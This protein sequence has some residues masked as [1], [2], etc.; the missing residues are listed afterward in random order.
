MFNIY[1]IN[2]SLDGSAII[3]ASAA[4][5]AAILSAIISTGF[6]H[7][8]QKKRDKRNNDLKV[9][10]IE[11]EN[12][13]YRERFMFMNKLELLKL[14]TYLSAAVYIANHFGRVTEQLAL[15]ESEDRVKEELIHF[16]ER[17]EMIVS[18]ENAKYLRQID[19]DN[20]SELYNKSSALLGDIARD[21]ILEYIENEQELKDI[22]N[23]YFKI[24]KKLDGPNK[25]VPYNEALHSESML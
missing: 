13:L 16:I 20:L 2:L 9:K 22:S 24:I 10:R 17:I 3:T 8:T 15:V 1:H 25:N 4:I 7:W 5:I 21:G 14:P 6:A 19:V 23:S 11:K 18:H 12:D